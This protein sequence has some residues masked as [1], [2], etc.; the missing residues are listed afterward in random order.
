[1]SV[2]KIGIL[3]FHRAHNYGAMLQAYAL[4][5]FLQSKGYRV[6]IIDYWPKELQNEYLWVPNYPYRST[7]SRIKGLLWFVLGFSMERKRRAG[8][9]HFILKYLQLSKQIRY[10][11]ASQ[12]ESLNYDV[13][14]YGSDQIW[15]KHPFTQKFDTVYWGDVPKNVLRK[16]AYGASSNTLNF[17]EDDLAF[18]RNKLKNFYSVGLREKEFGEVLKEY[19]ERPINIVLDP[20]FLIDTNVWQNLSLEANIKLPNRPYLLF[21]HLNYNPHIVKKVEQIARLLK[22]SVLEIR[23]R[24][25]PLKV[26][27]RY[28]QTAS[29]IDFLKL[30]NHADC[31]ITNSFHGTALSILFQKEFYVVGANKGSHRIKNLL[32]TLSLENRFFSDNINLLTDAIDYKKVFLTIEIL[33]NQS[34]E[35][36]L[37]SIEGNI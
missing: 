4:L 19:Y 3:T 36:L 7:L 37:R 13:V 16:I 31:V 27:S 25:F 6:E 18:F 34:R 23:G 22:L 21:Y 30:I 29:P 12:L 9:V 33:Q 10:K 20:V 28:C 26:G 15:R 32:E 5:E 24:V 35:F 11:T 14:I 2:K 17:S 1:M 8:Y